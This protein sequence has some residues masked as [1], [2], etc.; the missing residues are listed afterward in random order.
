VVVDALSRRP[1]IFSMTGVSVDWKDHLVM[2][3]A[4]DQF[5]CQLLDGQVQND[6]FRIINDLIYYKGRIVLVPQSAFK[7][8]VLQ[9]CHDSPIAGHQGI[10]KTYMQ[11]RERFSWKGLK[12]DV[13]K[14]VKECTTCQV[15]KDEHT[16]PTGLLQPLPIPEH[17]WESIS[18]DFITG[19]PRTK[20]KN[21][22]FVV[23]NRL[24]K[25]AHFFSIATD[26][27]ATQVDELLFKEFLRLHGLLKTI[28]NDRDSRFMSTF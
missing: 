8:K 27:S 18:M 24:T 11:V 2:E 26:F 9:V 17:K 22:I 1:S 25:F 6:N 14:H 4:K 16:H 23:V 28:V 3:Y 7:D 21:C 15:N 19:L 10:N 13:I 20:G 12:E 5:A